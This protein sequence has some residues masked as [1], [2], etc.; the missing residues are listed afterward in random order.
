M[1]VLTKGKLPVWCWPRPLRWRRCPPPRSRPR[2]RRRSGSRSPR[3]PRPCGTPES[4]T[5][6][7]PAET[8]SS[9]E[10]EIE[11]GI[12]FIALN[13]LNMLCAEMS[14]R[15]I[16]T[17]ALLLWGKWP[18]FASWCSIW[19]MMSGFKRYQYQT[20]MGQR[21]E[22]TAEALEVCLQLITMIP[23]RRQQGIMEVRNQVVHMNYFGCQIQGHFSR[24]SR[25]LFAWLSSVWIGA[26][27]RMLLLWA[28][29]QWTAKIFL[30]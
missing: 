20:S 26:T 27:E 30:C 1:N 15:R 16:W 29:N 6:A 12:Q 28:A 5:C 21:E 7:P 3:P 23:S 4:S 22:N 25:H 2:G 13:D 14:L 18:F 9:A 8:R 10:P 17:D 19:Q 11:R 24:Q